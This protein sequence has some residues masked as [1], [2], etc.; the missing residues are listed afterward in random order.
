[1]EGVLAKSIWLR[2]ATNAELLN[3]VMELRVA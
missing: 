3:M 2:I 1:L